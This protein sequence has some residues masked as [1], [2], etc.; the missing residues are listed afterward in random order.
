MTPYRILRL[1]SGEDIITRI[2]GKKNDHFLVDRPMQMKIS[3]MV[4]SEGTNHKDILLLRNWLQYT[5]QIETEI[6]VDWVAIIL[7]P[8]ENAVSSY[9]RA[10]ENE[11][12]N[13]STFQELPIANKPD[14]TENML[15][16]TKNDI[17]PGSIIVTL[18]IP[19][20]V[21]V[22][23]LSQG[24]LSGG[25]FGEMEEEEDMGPGNNIGDWSPNVEDYFDDED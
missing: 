19:P 17:E 11:D 22:H 23:L 21:F 18:A 7:T 14:R 9:D 12:C 24:L 4:D 3:T 10:K 5:T 8:D 16:N 6:P 13:P 25:M 20:M 1:R 2:K 15:P